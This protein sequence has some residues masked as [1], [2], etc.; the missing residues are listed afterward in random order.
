MWPILRPSVGQ[1]MVDGQLAAAVVVGDQRQVVRIVGRG[2]RVYHRDAEIMAQ[3]GADV[4]PGADHDEA[5]DP[6]GEQGPQMVLFADRVAAGV[7]QEH[8]GHVGPERVLGPHQDRDGEPAL[9]VGGEQPDRAAALGDEA[10][11]QRVG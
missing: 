11:G 2:V 9:K 10:F 7:A 5:V 8:R 1:Q 6:A 4:G 3:R